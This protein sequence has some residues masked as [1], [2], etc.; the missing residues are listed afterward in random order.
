MPKYGNFSIFNMATIRYL[1]FK[2]KIDI[3][4]TSRVQRVQ[5]LYHVKFRGNR[6]NRC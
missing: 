5:V 1:G 4:T 2:K 3:L 6:P